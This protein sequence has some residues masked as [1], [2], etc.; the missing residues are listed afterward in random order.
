MKHSLAISLLILSAMLS[1]C[2]P[3]E[4]PEPEAAAIAPSETG[5]EIAA[6]P[7]ETLP[8]PPM[9]A[10]AAGTAGALRLELANV[11]PLEAGVHYE[12][13]AIVN[14]RPVSTGKF[15]VD[16]GGGL[17][18][19]G[20]AT[21]RA[22]VSGAQAVVV[23]IEP[24][25][26]RDARPSPTKILAGPVRGGRAD[27]TIRSDMAL[28]TTFA[29]AGGSYILATP[30]DGMMTNETSGVWFLSAPQ[31]PEGPKVASLELPH[32]PAG[33]AYEGWAVI[34][35]TPVTTGR[36]QMASGRDGAAPFG[37]SQ[38]MPPFPG[39]DFLRNAP[40]G[41]LF[42][43]DL[44]GQMVVLTVEPNPDSSPKPF[45][46]KPLRHQVPTQGRPM[47]P[48]RLE[49]KSAELPRGTATIIG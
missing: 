14:G 46:L 8:P 23:T 6:A 49:N 24:A 3:E 37:G 10:A 33:W 31:G 42:P 11:V 7:P 43:T 35:G 36:F 48:Y 5:S 29:D 13:W 27:L 2:A 20:E 19:V 44:S 38:M 18:P 40:S 32:L 22:D 17:V 39:E 26:D 34:N 9:P 12:G 28:G 41:L 1:A 15:N 4:T 16:G 21:A 47:T 25:G 30:S 45:F